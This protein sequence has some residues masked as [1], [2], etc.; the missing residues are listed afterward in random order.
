MPITEEDKTGA[1]APAATETA[2]EVE[3]AQVMGG[4]EKT[5]TPTRTDRL[6]I[7]GIGASAGGLE[8]LSEFVASLPE[9]LD[10]SF[11]VVQH[12]SSTYRSMLVE[13]LQRKTPITVQEVRD[14]DPPQRGIIYVTP[15]SSSLVLRGGRFRLGAAPTDVVPKPSINAFFTSLAEEKGEDA[16]GVILSGTGTD[17]ANGMRLI[18]VNGGMCFAQEPASAKYN[19]MP[20]AAI[21]TGVVHRVLAPAAIAQEIAA[22]LNTGS[23]VKPPAEDASPTT[24][25]AGLLTNVRRHTSVDFSGYKDGTLW[26]RIK[27]RMAATRMDTFAEYATYTERNPE[28]M[29]QLFKDILISV[30]NFFRDKEAFEALRGALTEIV[31]HK[32]VGEELRIWVSG[33][34]TGEEAYSVAILLAEVMTEHKKECRVQIF[35]TDIDTEAMAVARRGIYTGTAIEEMDEGLV[36]KYFVPIE[37]GARFEVSRRLRDM[38]V[39]ARQDLTRDPPFL[40]LDLISCRNV[41]IY[42]GSELQSRVLSIFHYALAPNGHL[43]LGR[44]EGV[45]HHAQLFESAGKDA[46]LYRRRPGAAARPPTFTAPAVLQSLGVEQSRPAPKSGQ[47]YFA[48]TAASIYVPPAVLVDVHMEIRH[49]YGEVTPFLS[50]ASGSPRFELLHLLRP[51]FRTEVQPLIFVAERKGAVVYGKPHKIKGMGSVRVAVHPVKSPEGERFSL[52]AFEPVKRSHGRKHQQGEAEVKELEEQLVATRENLQTVIEELETSNEEMQALNEELQA[53]NEELQSSNEELEASNEEL[54]STNEELTT[55]NEE[56]RVKSQELSELNAELQSVE[57]SIGQPLLVVDRGLQLVRFN[58][59]AAQVFQLT[60][61]SRG[62]QLAELDVPHGMEELTGLTVETLT[63]GET[64][65]RNRMV[66]GDRVYMASASPF[67]TAT[68]QLRGVILTLTDS[69]D[70]V[71]AE[72]KIRRSREMLL[73]I[74]DNSP[75]LVAL[76]DLAGR[77]TF[78]NERYARYFDRE[79]HQL[80]GST[81]EEALP[82]SVAA[83]FRERDLDAI[84][85]RAPLDSDDQLILHG[86]EHHLDAIRFPVLDV[87]G[88]VESV[89]TQAIDVTE[90]VRAQKQLRLAAR[91]FEHAGEGIVVTDEHAAIVTVNDAFTRITGYLPEEAVGKTPNLLRSDKHDVTFY[92][93]MWRQLQE[94]GWWQGEIWNRRKDGSV[95]MEW[96]TINAV[97][98]KDGELL[99]YIGVFS[100]IEAVREGKDRLSY[101]ATH[102]ELTGLANRSLLQDRLQQLIAQNRRAGQSFAVMFIDLDDFKLVNDSAGHS[103]GDRLL[104]EAAQ[105]LKDVV[106]EADTVSRLGGDEFALL[107]RLEGDTSGI[108]RTAGRILDAYSQ[109]FKVAGRTAHVGASIG[110]AV[111]PEDGE[112]TESLLKA[113]DTAMY[114]AKDEGGN[115]FRFFSSELRLRVERRMVLESE[116]R[117]ALDKGELRLHFQPRFSLAD[118]EVVGI[119]ALLRWQHPEHG[120]MLPGKFIRVLADSGLIVPVGEW[121]LEQSILQ[122]QALRKA[123]L[124]QARIPVNV[125]ARQC[126]GPAFPLL[127]RQC[128][129]AGE[130]LELELTETVLMSEPESAAEQMTKLRKMGM[131]IAMDDFGTGYSSLRYLKDFPINVIKLD[132]GFVANL[133]DNAHDAAI[134]RAVVGMAEALSLRVVAEGVETPAQAEFVSQIG[135]QELQGFLTSKPLSAAELT[136]M[137][138]RKGRMELGG[139]WTFVPGD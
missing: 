36:R 53:A 110:I 80:V 89:C 123:G 1:A 130:A 106:R 119:E 76:K 50:I 40:R 124:T 98:G 31:A 12:M 43:F 118:G 92:E 70:T 17:G 105:R 57:N 77:Y 72:D 102:D 61:E 60:S 44:S 9:H 74:L 42:F 85:I 117:R 88:R 52:V 5:P 111:F 8:A 21:D 32:A 101:L 99:N 35:A 107:A 14:G 86:E 93:E 67:M 116:L 68:G 132:R 29:D 2:E 6:V 10:A 16:I 100:D 18:K 27:R 81:D 135:C 64:V 108:S 33:C 95:Y 139:N 71:A 126:R 38:V 69:T 83:Q 7:A 3:H 25:L 125:S 128:E 109:P 138:A 58:H 131:T 48:E 75:T 79:R 59:A 66:G 127:L 54:Q 120:L 19:G 37:N 41:L 45:Y 30:T 15:P 113:A 22:I 73:S 13:L 28:E 96:L 134:A 26:R 65:E 133:P 49:V 114:Q 20:L 104:R 136:A 11:V 34:A 129:K 56:M 90:R 78:V 39:F 51:E 84:R 115:T 137:L 4:V 23:P 97:H 122:A 63:K 24:S 94:N 62:R 46:K 55:V 91:V 87:S 112:T 82:Y 103:A 47:D 121:V